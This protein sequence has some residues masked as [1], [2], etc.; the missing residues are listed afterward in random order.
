MAK[1]TAKVEDSGVSEEPTFG[2]VPKIRGTFL[3]V[4]IIRIIIFLGLYWGP[5]ILGSYHFTEIRLA[6]FLPKY[7]TFDSLQLQAWEAFLLD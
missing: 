2:G 4:P 5:P 3:G 1:F 6:A 7:T